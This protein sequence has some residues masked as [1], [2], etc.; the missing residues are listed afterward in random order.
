MDDKGIYICDFLSEH[1][2]ILAEHPCSPLARPTCTLAL[3]ILITP[4]PE[5]LSLL[6]HPHT[7]THTHFY[8]YLYLYLSLSLSLSTPLPPPP[9]LTH[10]YP[11][12]RHHHFDQHHSS[13]G[14]YP[15]SLRP[16]DEALRFRDSQTPAGTNKNRSD[17]FPWVSECRDRTCYICLS[18]YGSSPQRMCGVHGVA[19]CAQEDAC[20]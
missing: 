16:H 6:T 2:D 1:R 10:T 3:N 13:R 17:A 11:G 5:I 4:S 12:V 8:L 19:A 7:H 15:G 20:T 18:T 14:C 9:R